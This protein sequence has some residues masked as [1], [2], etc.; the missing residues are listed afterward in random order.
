MKGEERVGTKQSAARLRLVTASIYH[1]LCLHG[2][3]GLTVQVVHM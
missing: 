1:S 3:E 2:E